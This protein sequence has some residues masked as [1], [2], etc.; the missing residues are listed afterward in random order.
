MELVVHVIKL[1]AKNARITVTNVHPVKMDY[2][3]L[4][5]H[6]LQAIKIIYA[7]QENY[8]MFV[9]VNAYHPNM[10]Y[11]AHA[12]IAIPHVLVAQVWLIVM[13][14][15]VDIIYQILLVFNVLPRA[16]PALIV[17]INV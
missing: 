16:I 14:A 13:A 5:I 17:I 9:K 7:S 10:Q 3:C 1:N 11:Q 8:F 12:K 2:I 15:I 4:T 6:A